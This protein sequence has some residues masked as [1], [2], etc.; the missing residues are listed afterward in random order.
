MQPDDFDLSFAYV[1]HGR[2]VVDCRGC[3]TSWIVRPETPSLLIDAKGGVHTECSCGAVVVAQFP[4]EKSAIDDLLLSRPDVNRNWRPG[5]SIFD[6]RIE[7]A[8][9]GVGGA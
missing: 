7:N 9:H 8:A 5:E 3:N 2:W 6:L 4:G 1:N